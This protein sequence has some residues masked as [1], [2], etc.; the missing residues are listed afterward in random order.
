MEKINQIG[1]IYDR[2]TTGDYYETVGRNAEGKV[3]NEEDN[4][5]NSLIP[6]NF[7]RK[8]VLDL[9][10]GNGRHSEMFY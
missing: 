6:Q 10:C 3:E 1:D 2:K 8:I 9:G 4:F 7:E 5:L